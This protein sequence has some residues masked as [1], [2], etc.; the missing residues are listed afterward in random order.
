VDLARTCQPAGGSNSCLDNANVRATCGI[1]TYLWRLY[2][3]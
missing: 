2:Q 3:I 1:H